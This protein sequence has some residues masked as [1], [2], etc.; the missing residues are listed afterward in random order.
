MVV[1]S[2]HLG[3]GHM[4][5]DMLFIVVNFHFNYNI[6]CRV[7]ANFWKFIVVED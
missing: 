4:N 5:D 1:G 2:K 3:R 7:T 6:F